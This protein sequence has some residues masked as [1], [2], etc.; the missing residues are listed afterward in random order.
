MRHA[1]ILRLEAENILVLSLY[2]QSGLCGVQGESTYRE[3]GHVRGLESIEKP[4]K[5]LVV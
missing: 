2:L 1:T 5:V 3:R 4:S